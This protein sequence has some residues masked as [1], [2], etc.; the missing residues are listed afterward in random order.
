MR[1]IYFAADAVRL[2]WPF[3]LAA[4]ATACLLTGHGGQW[5]MK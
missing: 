5:P 4:F 1:A 2:V 3:L